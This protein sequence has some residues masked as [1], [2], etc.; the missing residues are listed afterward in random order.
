MKTIEIE[1]KEDTYKM[2]EKFANL[3]NIP[4]KQAI[5]ALLEKFAPVSHTML[6]EE[7]KKGYEESASVNI[8]WANL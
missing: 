5:A 8:D 3:R 2:I 6:V 4:V 7:L 1:I